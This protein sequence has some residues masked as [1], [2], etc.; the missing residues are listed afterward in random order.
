[1]EP[2]KKKPKKKS[3][4]SNQGDGSSSS[5]RKRAKLVV[6]IAAT[7]AAGSMPVANGALYPMV[8]AGE[9]VIALPIDTNIMY[10]NVE[11]LKIVVV[12]LSVYTVVILILVHFCF[13][14]G[15]ISTC[16]VTKIPKQERGTPVR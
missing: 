2:D 9:R 1:M 11:I 16:Q 7:V 6:P 10:L 12:A 4:D 13:R 8:Q 14:Q 15:L 3:K 5:S